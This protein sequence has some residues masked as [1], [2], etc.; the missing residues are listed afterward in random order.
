MVNDT[1]ER[2][3]RQQARKEG[4]VS[5]VTV[6][7]YEGRGRMDDPDSPK[8]SVRGGNNDPVVTV[9]PTDSVTYKRITGDDP[10]VR[11][12]IIRVNSPG[13]TTQPLITM[14]IN[15]IPQRNMPQIRIVEGGRGTPEAVTPSPHMNSW[16]STNPLSK[17]SLL[18]PDK[19]D[20]KG[21]TTTHAYDELRNRMGNY[22]INIDG[23]RMDIL[24]PSDVTDDFSGTK[25]SIGGVPGHLLVKSKANGF[26]N[27][28]PVGVVRKTKPLHW[29]G[30]KMPD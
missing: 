30:E 19:A 27:K 21:H 11:P 9:E 18:E 12:E 23:E 10:R 15:D 24:L 16:T 3:K 8:I 1:I 13:L 22:S 28:E 2:W 20:P 6:N 5:E 7:P 17:S 14:A 25:M 26:Y 29:D 4:Q